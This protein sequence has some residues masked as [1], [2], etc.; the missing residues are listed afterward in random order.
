[1]NHY[2]KAKIL[3]IPGRDLRI[4]APHGFVAKFQKSLIG[5]LQNTE[6]PHP[7]KFRY[8]SKFNTLVIPSEVVHSSLFYPVINKISNHLRELL[9][10]EFVKGTKDIFLVGGF[11]ES[12]YL[13]Q[14]LYDRFPNLN[15]VS[16]ERAYLAVLKGALLFGERPNF[17]KGRKARYTYGTDLTVKYDPNKYPED[18]IVINSNGQATVENVFDKVVCKGQEIEVDMEI[19]RFYHALD[20]D[21][22]HISI[23]LFCSDYK[24]PIF[25]TDESIRKEGVLQVELPSKPYKDEDSRWV[26][27]LWRFG[28]TEINARATDENGFVKNSSWH[29][30]HT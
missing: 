15:F 4:S 6:N 8:I 21:Q 20:D 10:N 13:Q 1:M 25:V 18:K 19:E 26:R 14:E 17:L 16:P 7:S 12:K 28:T 23:P 27:V 2:E 11:A 30:S 22:T 3:A 24:N 5:L 29:Y 9:E